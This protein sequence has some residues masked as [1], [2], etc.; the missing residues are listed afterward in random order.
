MTFS[1]T[2]LLFL[3]IAAAGLW[4]V[5]RLYLRAALPVGRRAARA[6][7]L[8]A[9]AA[10]ILLALFVVRPARAL[11]PEVFHPPAVLLAVDE[12]PSY[13]LLGSRSAAREGLAAARRHYEGL[14]FRVLETGFADVVLLDNMDAATL[15]KAVA[16]AGGRVVLEA[17]G[18]ITADSIASIAA[19]GVDY[20]SSG[21]ITHSAPNLDVALDIDL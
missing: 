13:A 8:L 18:G 6:L 9:G 17:S 21:A 15:A 14:G 4:L 12:S 19:T 5:H 3:L 2:P 10:W 20:A 1:A 16:I 11:D 7:A